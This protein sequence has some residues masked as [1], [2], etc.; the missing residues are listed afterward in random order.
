[1]DKIFKDYKYIIVYVDDILI[2]SETIE[3]HRK[4]LRQFLNICIKR[5]YCAIRKKSSYRIY[6]NRILDEKGIRLQSH[7]GKKIT[8]FPNKL[9]NK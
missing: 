6:E 5:R 8:E 7:L 3:D 2:A 4:H 9:E 1:M